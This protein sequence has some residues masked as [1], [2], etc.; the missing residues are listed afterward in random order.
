M[1][2]IKKIASLLLVCA[3][4]VL[5]FNGL[6]L[7]ASAAVVTESTTVIFED[8]FSRADGAI[9]N[10]WV[11]GSK[12]NATI[13]SEKLMLKTLHPEWTYEPHI[14]ETA[15]LRPSS[16][17]VLNQVVSADFY[18]ASTADGQPEGVFADQGGALIAR[19]QGETATDDNCYRLYAW[20]GCN[21]ATAWATPI[22]L[23]NSK[24]EVVYETI[25]YR[26]ANQKYR[27]ELSAISIDATTTQLGI[28]MYDLDENGNVTGTTLDATATDSD[29]ALQKAG[30][31]GFSML[32]K[33]S[34][35][36][37]VDNFKYIENNTATTNDDELVAFEDDFNRDNGTIHNNNG[38]YS[39]LS[40]VNPIGEHEIVDGVLEVR[41]L[42][43]GNGIS[44]SYSRYLQNPAL[45]QR[46]SA[47][48]LN[49]KDMKL[50]RS[51]AI[52]TR[53]TASNYSTGYDSS[54][55]AEFTSRY[56]KLGCV[57]P[58]TWAN[59]YQPL[60][61][62]GEAVYY[63]INTDHNY[64][65][66]MVAQGAYPTKLTATLYDMTAG[67]V[68]VATVTGT[69]SKAAF[70]KA[71]I[72][73]LSAKGNNASETS[74]LA[75]IDNF[76]YEYPKSNGVISSDDFNRADGE[77]E[78][79][80][81][82]SGGAYAYIE[83]NQVRMSTNRGSGVINWNYSSPHV[84]AKTLVRPMSEAALNQVVSAD[85]KSLSTAEGCE[86]GMYGNQG[87]ALIARCQGETANNTN[88]YY[89]KVELG[90]GGAATNW[91]A[92]LDLY[93]S[94][95]TEPIHSQTFY[96]GSNQ[97]YRLTFEAISIN[98]SETQLNMYMYG[99]DESGNVISTIT[100]ASVVDDDPN[101]QKAGTAGFSTCDWWGNGPDTG[102]I[103]VDNFTYETSYDASAFNFA[104]STQV[105]YNAF[106]AEAVETYRNGYKK[107]L[108]DVANASDLGAAVQVANDESVSFDNATEEL[109][110]SYI[111]YTVNAARTGEYLMK[112]R[113]KFNSANADADTYTAVIV[114]GKTAYKFDNNV[115]GEFGTTDAVKVKLNKGVNIIYCLAPTADVL[116]IANDATIDYDCL[117]IAGDAEVAVGD[118][119]VMGDANGDNVV[120]VRD[121]VRMKKYATDN[122]VA[123][124]KVA[125][126]LV[127]DEDGILGNDLAQLKKYILTGKDI[128]DFDKMSWL[129]FNEV[130]YPEKADMLKNT[131]YKLSVEKKL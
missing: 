9:G 59:Q 129:K 28:K 84:T 113:Y 89:F 44:T 30:T 65:I 111:A 114:N 32:D 131:Y 121:L 105:S 49:L 5:P 130:D 39:Q 54:Y 46:V 128:A 20:L 42:S 66:E 64:R 118:I 48:I 18:S 102:V 12:S 68:P 60:D 36:I 92:S 73:A 16:E 107:D 41:D 123:I 78:N 110:G 57:I 1:K 58:D 34:G 88:C 127:D 112:L 83:S 70:Q 124:D 72:V 11:L 91:E 51:A 106:E 108:G 38:W 93:N 120:D 21:G 86:E 75:L 87:G 25:I 122:S 29:P 24:G 40:C 47:D 98:S 62:G 23:L 52:H 10:G 45:N 19:C 37:A 55:Y 3:L 94:E 101:L 33:W 77:I 71:G 109:K 80:W 117:F 27:L 74:N 2:N 7:T 99:L 8:D 82:A 119:A 97:K 26:G 22:T 126:N 100:S 90:K 63:T 13:S 69:D 81:K 53:F 56:I 125:A 115:V 43:N 35:T 15:V 96:V 50:H 6:G 76:K 61:N 103:G 95:S 116:E 14:A 4:L 17:A 67:G 79:G 104:N 31:A 85:F